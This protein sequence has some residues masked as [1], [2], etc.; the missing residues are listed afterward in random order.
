MLKELLIV[1]NIILF[2]KQYAYAITNLRQNLANAT[3]VDLS[4]GGFYGTLTYNITDKQINNL[5]I[6]AVPK[7]V[8]AALMDK[9]EAQKARTEA[10]QI[11]K[12]QISIQ[13]K[14]NQKEETNPVIIIE[15]KNGN[16][17]AKTEN[18]PNNHFMI[19]FGTNGNA[20]IELQKNNDI[21]TAKVGD[22]GSSKI[23]IRQ[24]K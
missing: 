22:G 18:D 10:E 19:D 1:V 8:R 2:I 9:S 24:S 11:E 12:E 16:T 4:E 21:N 17:Y 23:I 14:I 15:K 13:T 20:S 7:E 5:L 6:V 3:R